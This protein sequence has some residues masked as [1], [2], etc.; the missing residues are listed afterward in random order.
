MNAFR[1]FAQIWQLLSSYLIHFIVLLGP[2]K[3][4]E[5]QPSPEAGL[6]ERGNH[7]PYGPG[8]LGHRIC[9]QSDRTCA[10]LGTEGTGGEMGLLSQPL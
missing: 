6:E 1:S 8:K 5:Q 10:E 2:L 9:Q 4:Q 3:S 7:K